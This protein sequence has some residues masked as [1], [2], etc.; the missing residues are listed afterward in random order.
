[1]QRR[2]RSRTARSTRR[3][4]AAVVSTQSTSQLRVPAQPWRK[5][6]KTGPAATLARLWPPSSRGLGRRPLTAETGVRIPVAVLRKL[7]LVAGFRR[8]RPLTPV[9]AATAGVKLR[10]VRLSRL[11]LPA[12]ALFAAVIA[13]AGCGRANQ[14]KPQPKPPSTGLT[15]IQE[16]VADGCRATQAQVDFPVQCPRSWPRPNGQG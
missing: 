7:A 6:A 2:P 11:L 14:A 4:A 15:R 1:M 8:F 12:V 13:L 9:A 16:K 10:G 3:Q 5:Q